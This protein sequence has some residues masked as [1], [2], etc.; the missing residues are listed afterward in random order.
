M[1][2]QSTGQQHMQHQHKVPKQQLL[3]THAFCFSL[4]KKKKPNKKNQTK[5]TN[6]KTNKTTK[7]QNQTK[8]AMVDVIKCLIMN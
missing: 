5:K 4:R 1:A 2:T 6:K 3:Q 8:K 7:K